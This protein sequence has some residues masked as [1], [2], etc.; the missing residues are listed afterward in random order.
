MAELQAP[1]W[2]SSPTLSSAPNEL[3][4]VDQRVLLDG[5]R[6]WSEKHL[7]SKLTNDKLAELVLLPRNVVEA[8]RASPGASS[9]RTMPLHRRLLLVYRL[10]EMAVPSPVPWTESETQYLR[11][12]YHE[13]TAAELATALGRS[14]GATTV[15]LSKLGLSKS[16]EARRFWTES[17]NQYLRDHYH[18]HTATELA[19]A[20][21][22][23]R[24]ATSMQLSKLG[25]S[26]RVLKAVS[27]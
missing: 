19:T 11:D 13:H 23:T 25:L 1:H 14:T 2:L 7:H 5:L 6:A 17:D 4:A 3:E 22:R 24:G 9:F 26:K 15:K 21:G 10:R 27:V 8:W 16:S 20:L 12:H 18:E